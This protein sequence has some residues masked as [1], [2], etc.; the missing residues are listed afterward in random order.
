MIINR[1]REALIQPAILENKTR[2]RAE[3]SRGEERGEKS[4]NITAI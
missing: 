2:P 3:R 1:P 4:S